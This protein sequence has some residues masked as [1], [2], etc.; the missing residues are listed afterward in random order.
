MRCDF[1][2]LSEESP[3]LDLLRV[4]ALEAFKHAGK[5]KALESWGLGSTP[6]IAND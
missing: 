3:R 2:K 1:K 4:S 5:N 6:E